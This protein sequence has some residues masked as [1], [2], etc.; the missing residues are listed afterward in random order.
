MTGSF[1]S[2]LATDLEAFIAF[3]RARGYRYARAEFTL[4]SFDRFWDALHR[5]EKDAEL[6]SAILAWLAS[7][8]SRQA[9]SVAQDLAVVRAFWAYLRRRHPRRYQRDPA[10]PQLP[11]TSS[12][13]PFVLTAAQ[14]RRLLGLI[15]GLGGYRSTL[16]RALFLL[17]YC[18]GLRFGEALRLRVRDID[19]RAGV[20]FVADSKGRSRWVPFHPSLR[21]ELA[22]YRQ[23]RRAFATEQSNEPFFVRPDRSGLSAK[24]ASDTFRVLYRLAGLKPER[25]RHGPRPYD[26]RHTFAVHRLTR[27]YRQGVDLHGRLPW[28][29]AYLGHV[30]LLGTE[31]YLT[32]TPEL[33]ALAGD[34]FRRRYAGGDKR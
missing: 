31:T 22:R 15:G 33:L 14:V 16:Y 19:L 1:A 29:S 2:P 17:L 5:R 11:N 32:A 28:L 4:R 18:T 24:R 13:V 25:G 30:N 9:I 26:I 6:H 12:F 10:W 23:R 34:R 27:W 20:V 7:R 21:R 8:P 3:K